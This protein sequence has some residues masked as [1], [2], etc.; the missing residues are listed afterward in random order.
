MRIITNAD[1]LGASPAVN[2]AVFGLI[3]DGLVTSATVLANGPAVAEACGRLRQF[4]RC[5]FGAH[6]NLTEFKP[7]SGSL[8]L[9]VL[10]NSGG[11]FNGRIREVKGLHRL[12][13]SLFAE[14]CAQIELLLSIGVKISHLDS[15]HHV[16]TIPTLFPVLKAVQ[17]K[18][19]I[20]R[21]RISL[22][23]YPATGQP[24]R[25]LLW[26]KRVFNV[27]LR[28]WFNTKTTEVF[29]DLATFC[30]KRHELAARDRSVEIMLHPGA[31]NSDGETAALRSLAASDP[32]FKGRLIS[33]WDL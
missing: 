22:N 19:G 1:D 24:S 16:H 20:R 5:S 9:G 18:Y 8:G 13:K 30:E 21:V 23:L 17:R 12:G 6:L 29:T 14:F 31:G 33:F 10:L 32:T 15:H 4:P 27:V 7:L 25:R 26:Q 2:E 28:S 3:A 11:C